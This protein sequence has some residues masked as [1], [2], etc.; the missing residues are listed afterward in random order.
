TNRPNY[1]VHVPL[2]RDALEQAHRDAGLNVLWSEY[3]LPLDVS[4][5]GV[6][7]I[8]PRWLRLP[9]VGAA[10][11]VAGVVWALDARGLAPRPNPV[12]SPYIFCVAEK[13]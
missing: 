3:I 1:D 9:A 10:S 7:G 2:D 4:L 6:G 11:V 13:R 8:G 5:F 12:T